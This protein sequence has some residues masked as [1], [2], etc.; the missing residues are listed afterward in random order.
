MEGIVGKKIGMTRVFNQEGQAIAVTVIEAG[1]CPVVQIKTRE[2]EGYDALQL[3]FGEKRKKLVTQPLMGH[4]T[5]AKVEPQRILREMRTENA[6]KFKVGQKLGVDL[7][8]VGEKVAVSGISKGLGFQ[9]TVRRYKFHGG[10]KTHGQSDRLR[11]PG[12]IGGSSYPSRVFKGQRM[13]GRMGGEK[14]TVRNLEVVRVDAEKN[15]L[16]LKGAVPG[17]RNSYL[18]IRKSSV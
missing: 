15:L 17:K 7:F 5:R 16:L 3:G 18:T 9:G 4:F 6:G 1:P 8:S 2:K 13:P 14:V 11:A 10:P 12:S